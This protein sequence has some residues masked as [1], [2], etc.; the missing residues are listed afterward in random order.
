MPRS[1]VLRAA[2]SA[3]A[4]VGAVSAAVALA[5]CRQDAPHSETDSE[6]APVQQED[7][8]VEVNGKRL[9]RRDVD[10]HVARRLAALRREGA[11]LDAAAGS[12]LE[13]E[14]V[15]QF[16]R[17]IVLLDEAGRSGI[18]LDE[19]DLDGAV[20]ELRSRVPPGSTFAEELKRRNL[21]ES[22]LRRDPSLRNGLLITKFLT[23]RV[24]APAQ[25]TEEELREEYDR[26][27]ERFEMPATVNLR[28]ILIA[29][30][31][32]ADAAEH[33]DKTEVATQCRAELLAGADMDAMARERSDGPS[34]SFGG[35]L[36]TMSISDL[37][38]VLGDGVADAALS[39]E[40]GEI[41]A[42]I[43]T[44]LGYHI[45]QVLDRTPARTRPLGEVREDVARLLTAR[46]L[47]EAR[48]AVYEEL[49]ES[50]R[51]VYPDS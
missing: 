50:A 44:S 4:L 24:G 41:S 29:C 11:V 30:D 7:F 25:L 22:S 46:K 26:G 14:L 36:G 19:S 5:G 1:C 6:A 48:A 45:V 37:R 34:A 16:V 40:T 20:A 8:V 17:E 38:A 47:A 12:I 51:I 9:L 33:T 10:A 21:T 15:E 42:V 35:A 43:K 31:A 2:V 13:R 39:Q 32:D 28:H 3:L 23:S 18:R 27:R 49:R